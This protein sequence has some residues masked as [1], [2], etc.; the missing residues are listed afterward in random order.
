MIKNN[1]TTYY[2]NVR[3]INGGRV[4]SSRPTYES[5]S[6][7][8]QRAILNP[9]ISGARVPDPIDQ[10]VISQEVEAQPREPIYTPEEA[11]RILN[12][13][14]TA[15]PCPTVVCPTTRSA[16]PIASADTP[17]EPR[18]YT[19]TEVTRIMEPMFSC[20][21]PSS[22]CDATVSPRDVG[23][24]RR[25]ETPMEPRRYSIAEVNTIM[26][27][28]DTGSWSGTQGPQGS[29]GPRGYQGP[30]GGGSGG[31]AVITTDGFTF[32]CSTSNS[33]PVASGYLGINPNFGSNT[34]IVF[35]SLSD[36]GSDIT[37]WITLFGLSTTSSFMGQLK[38]TKAD[39][40]AKFVVFKITNTPGN[41]GGSPTC[42]Q[43]PVEYVTGNGTFSNDD[44]LAVAFVATG[45][46]GA[47]GSTGL[48]GFQGNQ[49]NRG[50]YGNQGTQGNQGP[51]GS[52]VVGNQGHAIV[53]D[54]DASTTNIITP[55]A[56][57]VKGLTFVPAM[58]QTSNLMEAQDSN[59]NPITLIQSGGK[60]SLN[61]PLSDTAALNL[62]VLA[63][64]PTYPVS[65][66][67]WII[68][69]GS[70]LLLKIKWLTSIYVVE[71][72]S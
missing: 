71:L 60:L 72:T 36:F 1:K 67:M 49:G 23:F 42:Y 44:Q 46:K 63:S 53:S 69:S 52:Y 25:D 11:Q 47:T 6:D 68:K 55:Q 2:G 56:G 50:E 27:P 64:D 62:G 13:V 14:F 45:S 26:N 32:L 19:L 16:T 3:R 39:D 5:A 57:N 12:P 59:G 4:I 20:P 18:S 30:G 40:H 38:V 21:T 37:A 22:P 70:S 51:A 29:I 54:P 33:G 66:D 15:A 8:E 35:S 65:G 7:S 43:V 61:S 31:G 28:I 58:G 34:S 41:I 17:M 24:R 10:G 9:T 48:R